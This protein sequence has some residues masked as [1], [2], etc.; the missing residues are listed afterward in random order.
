MHK[1][2]PFCILLGPVFVAVLAE[3]LS[4]KV[5]VWRQL[6]DV[7]GAGYRQ[8]SGAHRANRQTHKANK[9]AQYGKTYRISAFEPFLFFIHVLYIYTF[10][11]V[12]I[13][14]TYAICI[15]YIKISLIYKKIFNYKKW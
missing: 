3:R 9:R 10:I 5:V 8:L 13:I 2:S 1:R 12:C 14:Y 6:G 4:G 11:Y 7:I 15:A